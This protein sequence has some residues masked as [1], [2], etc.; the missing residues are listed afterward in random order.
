MGRWTAEMPVDSSNFIVT[1]IKRCIGLRTDFANVCE[2]SRE[3]SFL[4]AVVFFE[5][6]DQNVVTLLLSFSFSIS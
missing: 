2:K 6:K 1:A 5:N 4:E 3:A